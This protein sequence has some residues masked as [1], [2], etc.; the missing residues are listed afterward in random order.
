MVKKLG[1]QVSLKNDSELSSKQELLERMQNNLKNC[2][3]A[4]EYHLPLYMTR[5]ALSRQLYFDM[6]YRLILDVPGVIC[7]FGVQWGASL[8]TLSSLRGIYE[9]YN[10]SRQL[11]GFDTF[12]GF[13]KVDP[14][15]GNHCKVGDYNVPAGYESELR[16]I[17]SI[18]ENNSPLA[19]IPKTHL[20]KGDACNTLTPWLE[21]NPHALIAMAIFDLDVYLPTKEALTAIL[22]RLT[23]GSVLVFDELNCP[24][25]P[26]ET[27]ALAEVIGLDGLRLRRMPHQP[28]CAWAVWGE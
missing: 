4:W 18:H 19:H 1:G 10:Y 12:S 8:A 13:S 11:Y 3:D 5:Q 27:M 9:P 14:K 22:P 26:G 2:G 16:A 21:F 20:I 23:R 25:F 24:Q 7:E 17:L 6:L 28:Y 15:D